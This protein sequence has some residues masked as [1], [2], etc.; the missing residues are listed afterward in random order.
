[1]RSLKIPEKTRLVSP[2]PDVLANKVRLL[3]IENHQIVA[4]AVTTERTRSRRHG[5][6]M[7]RLPVDDAGNLLGSV[8]AHPLPNTHDISTRGVHNLTSSRFDRFDGGKLRT[9]GG[10][11]HDILSHELRDLRVVRVRGQIANAHGGELGVYL[12]VV[13]DLAEQ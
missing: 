3:E 5:F 12:R 13:N 11:D 8:L 7:S 10:N 6:L 2:F 1:M 4:F 9:E